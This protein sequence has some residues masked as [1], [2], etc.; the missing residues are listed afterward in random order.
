MAAPA[1][2]EVAPEAAAAQQGELFT[3]YDP[4]GAMGGL[5]AP[6]L[7]RGYAPSEKA[8]A[9]WTAANR[10]TREDVDAFRMPNPWTDPTQ[11]TPA[12][13]VYSAGVPI[14]QS[15][16]DPRGM[17]DPNAL[18]VW[19]QG[20]KYNAAARRDAIAQRLMANSIASAPKPAAPRVL[21]PYEGMM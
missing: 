19:S 14:N 2:P 11:K 20:G 21:D 1:V 6:A 10:M 15:Y 9:D 16:G 4:V 3:S 7:I 12:D 8:V 18:R 13:G 17:V 5:F